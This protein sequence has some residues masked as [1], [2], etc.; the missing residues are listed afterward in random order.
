MASLELSKYHSTFSNGYIARE[1]ALVQLEN[2]EGS[3]ARSVKYF[4]IAFL[5]LIDTL[6]VAWKALAKRGP[7][8]DYVHVLE[9]D[10]AVETQ[11][12]LMEN[13]NTI[14]EK[15]ESLLWKAAL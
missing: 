12:H 5:V 15:A 9:D 11:V 3:N 6:A 10:V 4:L 1:N 2:M 7:Y 8:D 14:R 13:E